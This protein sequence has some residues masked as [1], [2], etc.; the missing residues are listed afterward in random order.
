MIQDKKEQ[1]FS[2]VPFLYLTAPNTL[3]I[4]LMSSPHP[5]TPCY[6]VSIGQHLGGALP[7]SRGR[8]G[9]PTGFGLRL[10]RVSRLWGWGGGRV[11]SLASLL[12]VALVPGSLSEHLHPALLVL[13]Q[14]PPEFSTLPLPLHLPG[15]VKES[16]NM[17]TCFKFC[18]NT[19]SAALRNVSMRKC[20]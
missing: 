13:L 15:E 18:R 8:R 4:N 10:V 20:P 14:A 5:L 1:W 9:G 7:C 16:E 3:T 17:V 12:E 11:P 2:S 6:P 19:L